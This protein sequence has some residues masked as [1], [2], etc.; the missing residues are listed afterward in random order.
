[1]ATCVWNYMHVHNYGMHSHLC[2][3]GYQH[4]YDCAGKSVCIFGYECI[5]SC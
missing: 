4:L 2:I 1:M 3:H 5:L